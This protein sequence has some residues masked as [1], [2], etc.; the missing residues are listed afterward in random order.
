MSVGRCKFAT[1]NQ[2]VAAAELVHPEGIEPPTFGFVV[3]R[4]IQ[5]SYECVK[6]CENKR[7]S[8][9]ECKRE[10]SAK[11]IRRKADLQQTTE[12]RKRLAYWRIHLPRGAA[13]HLTARPSASRSDRA[14]GIFGH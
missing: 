10:F 3:R 12:P 1:A 11:F 8:N 6:K 13:Q 9:P 14:G 2:I 7:V 4:S 5:L